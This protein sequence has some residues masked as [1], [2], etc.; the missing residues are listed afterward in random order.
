MEGIT[1]HLEEMRLDKKDQGD[2][3]HEQFLQAQ[4]IEYGLVLCFIAKKLA[5]SVLLFLFCVVVQ[6]HLK[7]W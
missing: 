4:I 1:L 3:L 2:W 6:Q 5:E 7:S